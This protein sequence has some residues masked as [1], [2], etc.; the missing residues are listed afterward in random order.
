MIKRRDD[1]DDAFMDNNEHSGSIKVAK[2][3][4]QKNDYCLLKKNSAP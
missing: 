1:N 4:D 2:F 3:L